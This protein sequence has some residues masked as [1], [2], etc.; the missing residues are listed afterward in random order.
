MNEALL[1]HGDTLFLSRQDPSL[2]VDTAVSVLI[3]GIWRQY[4][5]SALTLLRERVHTNHPLTP[6]CEGAIKVAAKRSATHDIQS[7]EEL[8]CRL[9]KG[10]ARVIPINLSGAQGG[11]LLDPAFFQ[12]KEVKPTL[13]LLLK[14]STGIKRVAA[15]LLGPDGHWLG[16]AWNTA[17]LDRSAHAEYNLAR[18]L[19]LS[20]M[21]IPKDST[22]FVSLRPC[23]MCA[24]A[25]WSACES[26]EEVH[27]RFLEEDPGPASK[28]S[29]LVVYSD[30]WLRAGS[31]GLDVIQFEPN[32]D[33][34]PLGKLPNF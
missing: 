24:G 28:N 12:T 22:L 27:I 20:G 31:P 6:V 10:V 11:V 9:S 25:I 8:R 7:F 4:P 19:L 13:D 15:A 21:K 29:C 17:K 33:K 26:L 23:A 32:S 34:S 1:V 5:S 30:L 18:G 3:H 14:R 2:P 16:G